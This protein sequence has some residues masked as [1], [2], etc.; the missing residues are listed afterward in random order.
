M[1]GDSQPPGCATSGWEVGREGGD[2]CLTLLS[3]SITWYVF[4][5]E[6]I[7]L[8]RVLI[9]IWSWSGVETEQ[10]V[11][12]VVVWSGDAE[13]GLAVST[14][15]GDRAP[16]WWLLS[17]PDPFLFLSL[18]SLCVLLWPPAGH[19]D[20]APEEQVTAEVQ[21]SN[22]GS[23]GFQTQLCHRPAVGTLGQSLNLCDPQSPLL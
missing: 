22:S 12:R 6:L 23:Y 18:S 21:D 15:G 2:I 10:N 5:Q 20:M 7:T 11:K 1:R 4:S 3:A 13:K 8:Q 16:I 9:N 14:G 19:P 17:P